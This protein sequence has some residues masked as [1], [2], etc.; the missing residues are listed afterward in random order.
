MLHSLTRYDEKPNVIARS[1]TDTFL[2]QLAFEVAMINYGQPSPLFGKVES[3][4]KRSGS[5]KRSKS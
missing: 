1:L 3:C 2:H 5:Y 4:G